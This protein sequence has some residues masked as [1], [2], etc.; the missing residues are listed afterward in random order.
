MWFKNLLLYRFTKPFTHNPEQLSEKLAEKAFKPCG[1]QD[2]SSYGWVPPLG[3]HGTEFVHAANGYIMLCAKRQE[4]VLPAAVINEALAEKVQEIK[5][6]DSRAVGRK[7]RIEL[8]EEITFNLMPRAFARS[9]TVFA[10]IAPE[11]GLLV[12][13]ASSAKRAEELM[14]YLRETI[15][16]LPVIP[17]TANNLP[18]HAMTHWLKEGE[19]PENFEIGTEC[20]LRNPTDEG[21]VIRCKNQ[22]LGSDE[23]NAHLQTGMYVSKLALEWQGGISCIVDDQLSVKRL[24]FGDLIQEKVDR[25]DAEDAA[26]QF[27][28][29]FTIMTAEFDG[30]IKNLMQIFGGEDLTDCEAAA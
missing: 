15:G 3:Q 27:D 21:S 19:T 22:D 2:L 14:S 7:E 18:Q 29:D 8:K 16:S 10:Y 26:Q 25:E 13:N 5:A 12:V 1:S 17:V 6:Q 30:F 9:S 24:N 4:K 28:V 20:E 11:Q 23:I